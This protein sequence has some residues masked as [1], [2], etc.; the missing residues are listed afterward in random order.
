MADILLSSTSLDKN[1]RKLVLDDQIKYVFYYDAANEGWDKQGSAGQ[2]WYGEKYLPN[3]AFDTDSFLS[4]RWAVIDTP[5]V[6]ESTINQEGGKANFGVEKDEGIVGL[7]SLDRWSLAGDFEIRLYIDWSSYYNEYRSA[8][9]SFLKVSLNNLNSVRVAFC[10]DGESYKFVSQKTVDKDVS[11]FDWQQNGVES[12]VHINAFD[13]LLNAKSY[14]YFKITRVSGIIETFISDGNTDTKVGDSVD[15]SVFSGNLYVDFGVEAQEH[16]TYRHSFTKFFVRGTVTPVI[17]FFSPNRGPSQNFPQHSIFAIDD[18]A[19]SV[20]DADDYTLWM[21]FLIGGDN[22]LVSSEFRV[23]A[24]N[25]VVYVTSSNGLLAFDFPR[26]RIFKYSGDTIYTALDPIALRNSSQYFKEYLPNTGSL[27]SDNILDVGCRSLFGIDYV[28]IATDAGLSV[29]R[30]LASGISNSTD[31]PLPLRRTSISETGSVYWSGYD[32][33]NNKGELS[34]I[35]NI[36]LLTVSGT[37]NLSRTGF[38]STSTPIKFFGEVIEA[39]D[40]LLVNGVD[41]LAVGTSEGIS[42]FGFSPGSPFTGSVSYGVDSVNVN[43]INDPSFE[44]Y[45]GIDWK[46]RYNGFHKGFYATKESD[47]VGKDSYSLRLVFNSLQERMFYTAGTYGGIYQ[48]IDFSNVGALYYDIKLVCASTN[49]IWNFQILVG[50]A[51]VKE[52][53]D[54]DGS[55]TKLSDFI[56]VSQFT[57]IQRLFFRVYFPEDVD[58]PSIGSSAAL[59]NRF[60]YIDNLRVFLGDPDYRIL[61]MG[62]ASIRDVLLQYDSAGHKIYFASQG[63]YGA[64]DLDDNSLDYFNPIAKRIPDTEILSADFSKAVDQQ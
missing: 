5:E 12:P 44:G 23:K 54:I 29:K 52:Y 28:A 58:P 38:Y 3:D 4:D 45:L 14:L 51:V 35:S 30:A 55:F 17:E 31:G 49:N 60:V 8:A 40:V 6:S 16:N 18:V 50:D 61:P 46:T 15:D 57:G 34:Y 11:F 36:H 43:P 2:S 20:I 10:F 56:D 53:R 19:L 13:N 33:K 62:N 9:F 48:D 63:G 47:F 39:F 25:G 22:T 1:G 27:L 21:R 37:S 59:N 41:L 32:P 7:S 24:C 26:D 42:F 64:V